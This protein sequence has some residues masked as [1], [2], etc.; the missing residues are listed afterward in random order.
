MP[1]DALIKCNV[2]LGLAEEA[3][4]RCGIGSMLAGGRS[5]G[6]GDRGWV[7][8]LTDVLEYAFDGNGLGDE[9]DDAPVRAVVGATSGRAHHGIR[10]RAPSIPSLRSDSA[11]SRCWQARVNS[12]GASAKS[13]IPSRSQFRKRRQ[14]EPV[15]PDL[16]VP[17]AA[18][19]R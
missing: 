12:T 19:T 18:A 1:G 4:V 16:D 14:P 6:G 5:A 11:G 3:P 7:W 8:Q 10:P 9:G 15:Y 13:R 2:E 17:P